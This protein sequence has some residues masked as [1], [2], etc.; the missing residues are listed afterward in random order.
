MA[1]S[2]PAKFPNGGTPTVCRLM[3]TPKKSVSKYCVP[4]MSAAICAGYLVPSAS[5]ATP[6]PVGSKKAAALPELSET[7]ADPD[8]DPEAVALELDELWSFVPKRASKRWG[9]VGRPA[10]ASEFVES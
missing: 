5:R 2:L 6:S 9:R 8:P 3:A 4:I 10:P 7:L 1:V